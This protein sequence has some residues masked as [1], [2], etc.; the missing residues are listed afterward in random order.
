MPPRSPATGGTPFASLTP[1]PP[2]ASI[3]FATLRL[4]VVGPLPLPLSGGGQ[5]LLWL[6]P[7]RHPCHPAPS[8]VIM[9][10][11]LVILSAY[12]VI[13]SFSEGSTK[14]STDS[15]KT[16]QLDIHLPGRY[17]LWWPTTGSGREGEAKSASLPA[18]YLFQMPG[19]RERWEGDFHVDQRLP[20]SLT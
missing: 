10:A 15:T 2:N 18:K 20:H 9:N 5:V 16:F 6:A 7:R 1:A 19:L 12:P 17:A 14:E 13:L 4:A 11:H 8:S 3:V